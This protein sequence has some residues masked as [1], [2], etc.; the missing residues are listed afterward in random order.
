MDQPP[1]PLPQSRPVADWYRDPE[2][3]F[4]ER[5]WDGQEWTDQTRSPGPSL[6]DLGDFLKD[7]ASVAGS[8]WKQVA[9]L[10]GCLLVPSVLLGV[11]AMVILID[12]AEYGTGGLTGDDLGG[13]PLVAFVVLLVV[14]V[15]V[16]VAHLTAVGHQ[17]YEAHQRSEPATG[18]PTVRHSLAVA[19]GRVLPVTGSLVVVSAVLIAGLIGTVVVGRTAAGYLLLAIPALTAL[20]LWGWVK[21]AFIPIAGIADRAGTGI[22]DA[23]ASVSRGWFWGVLGRLLGLSILGY[24]FTSIGSAVIQAGASAGSGPGIAIVVVMPIIFVVLL[25]AQIAV[26]MSGTAMLYLR[27][28]ALGR[29]QD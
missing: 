11:V 15:V 1:P 21:A 2:H 24:A 20:G 17:M 7:T 16:G 10:T 28:L 23:S 22:I 25:A 6:P 26:M 18:G 14:S 12:S 4:H 5:Y 3:R 8:R 29:L 9:G 13:L 27:T 19:R